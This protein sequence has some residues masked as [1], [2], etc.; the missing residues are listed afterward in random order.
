MI[1]PV[2][3]KVVAVIVGIYVLFGVLLPRFAP[4]T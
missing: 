3:L 4:Y 1:W 2:I